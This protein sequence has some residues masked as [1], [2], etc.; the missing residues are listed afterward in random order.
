MLTVEKIINRLKDNN[1][2]LFDFT[3]IASEKTI[4]E[5]YAIYMRA[6]GAYNNKKKKEYSLVFSKFMDLLNCFDIRYSNL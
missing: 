5:K 1:N 6:N 2:G 3:P 4:I